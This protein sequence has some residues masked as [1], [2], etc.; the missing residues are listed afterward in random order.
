MNIRL[1]FLLSRIRLSEKSDTFT[2][3][4]E[5]RTTEEPHSKVPSC[6]P[7][8]YKKATMKYFSHILLILASVLLF[9][10]TATA[11]AAAADDDTACDSIHFSLL[12][13]AAGGEIYYLFGHTAIRYENFTRGVDIVFNYGVFD[14]NTPNFTS[15]FALGDTYYKLG[16]IEYRYFANEYT[17]LGRDVW[18]Q[19]LNLTYSEKEHLL[20]RLQE[21]YRSENR[22]YL[23][24]FFYDNCATRPRDQIEHVING[25]L[26][27]AENMTDNNTG[28]SF[29]DMLHT[30]NEGHPWAR[31]G[32]D[33]CMGSKAD[34]PISRRKMMFVPFLLQEYFGRAQ[35]MDRQGRARP[36]VASEKNIV[37]TGKIPADFRTEGITPMQTALLLLTAVVIATLGGVSRQKTLWGIDLVLFFAAGMAGCILTFLTLFSQHPAVSPNYLLFVFHPLHLLCLPCMLIRV[38]KKKMSRYMWANFVVLT[39]FIGLWVIIPQKF[40]LTVLPLALCLLIRSGS[41]LILTYKRKE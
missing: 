14:F 3:V 2:P 18:Q 23:Y 22:M 28:T 39:L 36:L 26:Q 1:I 40:P 29:R 31:F 8:Y 12:T 34:E 9:T 38:R 27:Y 4:C 20:R 6:A 7:A 19:T 24:N 41:N 21:N 10:P 25:T 15:R 32:M 35:I 11:H 17:A 5:A 33:L 37:A 30:Y 13:C 16:A